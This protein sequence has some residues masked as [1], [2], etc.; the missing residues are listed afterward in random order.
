MKA[1]LDHTVIRTEVQSCL[2]QQGK[3][4][5]R[6]GIN[7]CNCGVEFAGKFCEILVE[8]GCSSV[9]CKLGS[10]VEN[11]REAKCASDYA[12]YFG[13]FCDMKIGPCLAPLHAHG[14]CDSRPCL[15]SLCF[16][17]N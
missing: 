5:T 11:D 14:N 3:C 13:T 2:C 7:V 8:N 10:C 4:V 15:R 9:S 16:G 17:E 6:S 1:S 12:G